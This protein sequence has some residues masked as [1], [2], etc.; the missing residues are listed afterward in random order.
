MIRFFRDIWGLVRLT[1]ATS[2]SDP[3]LF[4]AAKHDKQR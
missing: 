2:G 4:D 1:E 3:P